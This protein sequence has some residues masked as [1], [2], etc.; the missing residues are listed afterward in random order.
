MLT[1]PGEVSMSNS[2]VAGPPAT[3]QSR[4]GLLRFWLL[5][6]IGFI[7]VYGP[8]AGA[9]GIDRHGPPSIDCPCPA[10]GLK[11]KRQLTGLYKCRMQHDSTLLT[12]G[13]RQCGKKTADK[14][15]TADSEQADKTP[16]ADSEQANKALSA[17]SEQAG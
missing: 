10:C 2:T 6:S 9:P 13:S 17:D 4:G 8:P 15:P 16:T 1:A 7:W 3:G 14:A 11:A 5:I 12:D